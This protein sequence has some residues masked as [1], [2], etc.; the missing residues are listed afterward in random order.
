MLST[1]FSFNLCGATF[2]VNFFVSSPGCSARK[3]DMWLQRPK[4]PTVFFT[5]LSI[6]L[7]VKLKFRILYQIILLML[8]KMVDSFQ[9]FYNICVL[10]KCKLCS[11]V[12]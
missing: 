3:K 12:R 9:N 10:L 4:F 2:L 7:K 1:A 11:N 6:D 8:N 5:L